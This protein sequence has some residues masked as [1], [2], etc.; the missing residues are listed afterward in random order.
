VL[1]S[2]IVLGIA[3]AAYLVLSPRAAARREGSVVFRGGIPAAIAI[4]VSGWL[5]T[6][7][8]GHRLGELEPFLPPAGVNAAGVA[9]GNE[10]PWILNDYDAALADARRQKKLVLI[11]FTG[12]TCT[13]CRWMEANMFPRDAVRRELERFVR[14][15]L[16]TD[17]REE[18][19][20]RQ[21][22]FEEKTFNTVALPLYAVVD[23]NGVPQRQFL[24]MTRS[25]DEFIGFL[26]GGQP[27]AK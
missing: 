5:A 7:L 23:G 1:A 17:G 9:N 11:D 15:R 12:Y 24:G 26:T 4:A 10:L 16:F 3:L 21:Q 8:F 6:G 20:V 14:V 18:S 19:N 27:I 2:W 22:A 13:N 25:S